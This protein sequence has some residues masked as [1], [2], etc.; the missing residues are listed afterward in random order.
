MTKSPTALETAFR[1]YTVVDVLDEGGAGRVYRVADESGNEFAAKVLHPDR[2]TVE[3][4]A[5]FKNEIAFC[6]R[7]RHPNVLTVIDHGVVAF[8][9]K[10]A[11]FYVMDLFDGS[12][13]RLYK[14]TLTSEAKLRIFGQL[15]DGVEAAHLQ[16]VYHR[17]LKP[18]NALYLKDHNRIVVAD[19]GIAH[20]REEQLFTAVETAPNTRL[21]NFLYAAPE[22]RSRGKNVDGRADIYALGLMLNELFTGHV[23]SGTDFARI[24]HASADLAYLDDIVDEM[25]RQDPERRPLKIDAIKANL[26]GRKKEFVTRQQLDAAQLRVVPASDLSDSLLDDPPRLVDFEW[27]NGTLTLVLSRSVN[28]DWIN[29]FQSIGSRQSVLGADVTNFQFSGEKAIVRAEYRS[30]QDIINYFKEWL[31]RAL[32]MYRMQLERKRTATENSERERLHREREEL[33]RQLALRRSKTI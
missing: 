8:E 32:A 4:R 27:A 6:Q 21:A 33:E 29:A 31:P 2:L 17:D 13:R 12:I 9:S 10:R 28:G 5:R 15:L 20:F 26:I 24:S 23:P 16:G 1:L 3:R 25:I 7:N 19:F 11:P 14:S 18:E 30:V 22:Q